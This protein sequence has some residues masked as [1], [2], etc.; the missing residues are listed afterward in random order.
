MHLELVLG[1][2]QQE[3]VELEVGG[4]ALAGGDHVDRDGEEVC[5]GHTRVSTPNPVP[6]HHTGPYTQT[7]RV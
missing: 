1:L 5:A 6:K 4:L 2:A 3:D 7:S